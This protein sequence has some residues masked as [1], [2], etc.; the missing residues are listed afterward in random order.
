MRAYDVC[1][2]IQEICLAKW[3]TVVSQ[4]VASRP[5]SFQRLP[6]RPSFWE[7]W[8]YRATCVSLPTCNRIVNCAKCKLGIIIASMFFLFSFFTERQK[9][10]EREDECLWH[11]KSELSRILTRKLLSNIQL[12]WRNVQL[13]LLDMLNVYY[14]EVHTYIENLCRNIADV[15]YI[16]N[17]EICT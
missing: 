13:S 3:L 16:H 10:R 17:V 6:L 11:Y 9:E 4:F 14:V 12:Y 2:R 7:S 1:R 15:L 5:F 8:L